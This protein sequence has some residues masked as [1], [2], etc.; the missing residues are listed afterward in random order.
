[1]LEVALKGMKIKGKKVGKVLVKKNT[2]QVELFFF[3]CLRFLNCLCFSFYSKI[4]PS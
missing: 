3:F 1:M 2:Q 4:E